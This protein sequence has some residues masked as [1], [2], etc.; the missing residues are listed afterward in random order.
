LIV[1]GIMPLLFP[2]C[3][4]GMEGMPAANREVVLAVIARS[5]ASSPAHEAVEECG[6]FS[7]R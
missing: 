4:P 7:L 1:L 3:R 6:Q 5:E 2:L